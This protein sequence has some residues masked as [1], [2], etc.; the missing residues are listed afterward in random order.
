MNDI[1]FKLNNLHREIENIYYIFSKNF[2]NDLFD[3]YSIDSGTDFAEYIF[4]KAD[5][6]NFYNTNK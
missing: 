4:A 5:L 2:K 3:N 1:W 6:L